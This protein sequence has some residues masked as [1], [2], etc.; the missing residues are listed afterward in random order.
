[1]NTRERLMREGRSAAKA[2]D[3]LPLWMK[4]IE[5][6]KQSVAIIK[7]GVTTA[8]DTSSDASVN[9]T[10]VPIQSHE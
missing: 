4:K 2:W 6:R 9:K 8:S 1:M 10:T 5:A 7:R 3:E